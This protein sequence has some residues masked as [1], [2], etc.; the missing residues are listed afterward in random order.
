M[1]ASGRVTCR[2]RGRCGRAWRSSG[3]AYPI[4]TATMWM[5]PPRRWRR[6]IAPHGRSARAPRA[7]CG[8]NTRRMT[9]RAS[10]SLFPYICR[11]LPLRLRQI[12]AEPRVPPSLEHPG[13]FWNASIQSIKWPNNLW[14]I[15]KRD[16]ITFS[17][18]HFPDFLNGMIQPGASA[19]CGQEEE[20][21]DGAA[22][23]VVEVGDVETLEGDG[24]GHRA[25]AEQVGV[26]EGDASAQEAGCWREAGYDAPYPG[27]WPCLL[28]FFQ[29]K[30]RAWVVGKNETFIFQHGGLPHGCGGSSRTVVAVGLTSTGS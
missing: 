11:V 13:I 25:A 24:A 10:D 7:N 14:S 16:Q 9:R 20:P 4:P 18:K 30:S 23:R 3:C 26:L 28:T 29:A 5:W 2:R 6:R 1:R 12:T 15:Q 17:R 27:K 8:R 22:C 19:R 21:S